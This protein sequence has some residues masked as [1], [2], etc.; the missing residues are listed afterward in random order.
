VPIGKVN[1]QFQIL[2]KFAKAEF[3]HGTTPNFD[4]K[5]TEINVNYVIKQFKARVMSFYRDT[6][7]DKVKTNFYQVGLGLQ[8]QI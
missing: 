4:Q 3:T 8:I 2:G 6:R 7:F 5:T 1:G